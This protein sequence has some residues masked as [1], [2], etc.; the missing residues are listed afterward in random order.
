MHRFMVSWFNWGT[1]KRGEMRV[2]MIAL[3]FGV[4]ART[5]LVAALA[6]FL[7][8]CQSARQESSSAISTENGSSARNGTAII[9]QKHGSTQTK[10]DGVWVRGQSGSVMRAG[11]E[12]RTGPDSSA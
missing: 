2:G 7:F 5:V 6:A 8:G 1:K 9:R 3:H 10:L 11:D 4:S 12:I